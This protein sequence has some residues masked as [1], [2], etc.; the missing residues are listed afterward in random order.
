M[1]KAI[2]DKVEPIAIVGMS[3]C[4]PMAR[5]IE[6]FWQN[7]EAEKDCITEIPKERWDWEAI[8]GDPQ[9]E[10]NKSNIKWGGFIEGVFEF[11]PL[12]F[13][14]SPREALL[15]DPQQR[16]LMEYVW[17]VIEDAGTAAPSLAGSRTGLF[18]G[19]VASGYDELVS[20]SNTPIEGYTS[21]GM[22][23]S[24]GPNRMSYFLD[25]HGPSEPIETACSSSLI[26]I[27][28]A[29][30]S[31]LSGE[32]DQA[33][34]GGINTLITPK[35]HISFNKAGMLSED[36][37][38]K[39]FSDKANGY[40]RGEGVGMFFLKKL[41]DAE[42]AGDH[43]Y[44]LIVGTAENH[45][46]RANSLTAPNPKAQA[47][48]LKEVYEKASVDPRTV[49]YI[50]AHGTGT[51]LGDPVEINGLKEAFSYLYEKYPESS[52]G[53]DQVPHCALG[54]VKSNVGHLEMAAGIAGAI[55]VILQFQHQK[56]VKSLHSETINPYIDLKETPFK[57][58]QVTEVWEPLKDQF[59]NR[60][61]RRAGVS[62]FGFG[63]ANAHIVLEEYIAP[64][65]A[66]TI[67]NIPAFIILSA[68]TQ[69]A[70]ESYAKSFLDFIEKHPDINIFDL[71]YTLQVGREGMEYR[72]AIEVQSLKELGEKLKSYLSDKKN[73][74]EN[75]YQGQV[76][77][78]DNSSSVFNSDEDMQKIIEAWI[79]KKK[80]HK[81]LSTW[82]EGL[83]FN[84][85]LLYQDLLADEKPHKI[86][87][88]TY[89]FKKEN[90]CIS[91]KNRGNSY[92]NN[93]AINPNKY[94]FLNQIEFKINKRILNDK[95]LLKN[96][97][98]NVSKG[99]KI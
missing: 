2:P 22:V 79:Q 78:N 1:Q 83:N 14:I 98:I 41:S 97:F 6:A 75:L 84:W 65:R 29:V 52:L 77:K 12:F 39:T 50:E 71:A 17:K 33:I 96:E 40:V 20:Q 9:T 8:Y 59:G 45:G 95:I 73:T 56:L 85:E 74:I 51:A 82:V 19:T 43:I 10:D 94:D 30:K 44:G 38:C 46:G 7:L 92:S 26:A 80:Y 60:I 37:R 66:E 16:L 69:S 28:R 99:G 91:M 57:I 15:M 61:P 11:D 32:C 93:V 25:I 23:P 18:I 42:N 4:F 88:P 90:F 64:T 67:L 3:G 70:L 89:P 81:L 34:A 86:G 27:H 5:D 63:G 31:I 76:K 47:D 48:L 35:A 58:Q 62:S 72:L 49:G 36:G 54:S 87:A 24:V 55:K 53:A 21:T 13:G 68:K